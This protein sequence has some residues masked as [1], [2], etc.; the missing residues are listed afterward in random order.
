[1]T[2]LEEEEGERYDVDEEVRDDRDEVE[3]YDGVTN[4]TSDSGNCSGS[5][6]FEIVSDDLS[7]HATMSKQ[8]LFYRVKLSRLQA[9]TRI[10]SIT[11][12]STRTRR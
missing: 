4:H 10:S 5:S 12:F 7:D 11:V 3:E 2:Y 8:N 1:V 9:S 6:S